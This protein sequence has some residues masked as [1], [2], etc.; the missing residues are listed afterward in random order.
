MAIFIG[1]GDEF[2]AGVGD[3]ETQKNEDVGSWCEKFVRSSAD[4]GS[5]FVRLKTSPIQHVLD[6]ETLPGTEFPT[7][8][9]QFSERGKPTLWFATILVT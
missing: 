8:L 6:G 5:C 3:A 4:A 9:R 1:S 2:S 7:P